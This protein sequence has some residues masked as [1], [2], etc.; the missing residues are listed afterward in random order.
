M[1]AFD[2]KISFTESGFVEPKTPPEKLNLVFET[3]DAYKG[4]FYEGALE[5]QNF[6]RKLNR[7]HR[8]TQFETKT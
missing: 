1:D 4:I 6:V 8:K 3:Y 2:V 5:N 7:F